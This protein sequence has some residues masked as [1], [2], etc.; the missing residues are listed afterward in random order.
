M[1]DEDS[2][3]VKQT[4]KLKRYM[5]MVVES[6]CYRIGMLIVVLVTAMK[7]VLLNPLLDPESDEKVTST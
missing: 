4:N 2:K 1:K 3:N 7:C 5:T 6:R